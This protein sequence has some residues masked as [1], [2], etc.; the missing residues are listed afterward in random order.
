MCTNVYVE[1]GKGCHS[2]LTD[3]LVQKLNILYVKKDRFTIS[4]LPED[5][6]DLYNYSI[7]IFSVKLYFYDH[8]KNG[9]MGLTLTFL[10]F[11]DES[12]DL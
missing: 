6:L 12:G 3:K 10:Y 11:N 9:R 2:V 8:H 5:F 1:E 4:K 7:W